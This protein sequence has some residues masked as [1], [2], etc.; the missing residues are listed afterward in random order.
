MAVIRNDKGAAVALAWSASDLQRRRKPRADREHIEQSALFYWAKL[1]EPHTPELALLFAIPNGG[2]RHKAVAAK[3]K[4]EGVKA[5]VPDVCLP[6]PRGQ[7]HGLYIEL[8]APGGRATDLQRNWL[9]ALG[10][11]GYFTRLCVGWEEAKKTIEDYL[12]QDNALF[13]EIS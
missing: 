12:R 5:G 2:H 7:Y 3:L 10:A 6:V 1:R 8:K 11:Q 4:A 13:S 9:L